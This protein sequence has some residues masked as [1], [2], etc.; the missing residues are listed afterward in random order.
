MVFVTTQCEMP[1]DSLGG[2]KLLEQRSRKL[3]V[4]SGGAT[5]NDIPGRPTIIVQIMIRRDAEVKLVSVHRIS[6]LPTKPEP[7]EKA[8]TPLE[9]ARERA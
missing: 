8:S 9:D 3:D 7:G 5:N 4:L 1:G 6:V 2:D